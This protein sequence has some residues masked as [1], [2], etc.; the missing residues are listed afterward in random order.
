MSVGIGFLNKF[1][2][3]GLP[4][5][6]FSDKGLTVD[7]FSGDEKKVFEYIVEHFQKFERAPTKETITAETDVEFSEFPDEPIEYWLNKIESRAKSVLMSKAAQQI[8]ED[9]SEGDVGDAAQAVGLLYRE[10]EARNPTSHIL[11]LSKVAEEVVILHDKLRLSGRDVS[12]VPFGFPTL[13]RISG[14]AQP[15][16]TIAFCGRPGEAKCLPLDSLAPTED[17]TLQALANLGER[18]LASWSREDGSC[19]YEHP[20]AV[21]RVG[22]K[23]CLKLELDDGTELILSEEHRLLDGETAKE[24]EARLFKPGDWIAVPRHIPKPE[25]PKEMLQSRVIVNAMMMAEGG[26]SQSQSTWTNTDPEIIRIMKDALQADELFLKERGVKDD[27]YAIVDEKGQS[28]IEVR[29]RLR[30]LGV[31][32]GKAVS[33][34]IDDRIFRLPQDQLALWLGVF[35]SCDGSKAVQIAVTLASKTM[36]Y[37]IRHLLLRFGIYSTVSYEKMHC[38]GKSFDAWRLRVSGEYRKLF[39]EQIPIFG[40]K[41]I[42]SSKWHRGN[43]SIPAFEWLRL[44]LGEKSRQCW[45][46]EGTRKNYFRPCKLFRRGKAVGVNRH[47]LELMAKRYKFENEVAWLLSVEWTQVKKIE[48]VGEKDCVDVQMPQSPWFI[49]QQ[50]IVHNSYILLRC[51]LFAY[52]SGWRPLVVTLEM[53][54][55]QCVRRILALQAHVAT[56]DVRLGRLT[57]WGEEMFGEAVS[58]V[59]V[60]DAER[61]FYFLQ[62]TLTTTVEDLVLRIQE[63]NCNVLYVD[64]A[65]LLHTKHRQDRWERVSETAEY[66]KRI[67]SEFELP[68]ISTYQFNRQGPGNLGNIAFSDSIGQ[69]ASIVVALYTEDDVSQPIHY[70]TMK[71][72]KGREGELGSIRLKFDMERT[73][74]EE[75]EEVDFDY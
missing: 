43:S 67:A 22:K 59:T 23:S 11:T 8:L 12:G 32:R 69:L 26:V 7:S 74:I 56:S 54:V 55:I 1:L 35:Y 36:V 19:L 42:R 61:P 14:G 31:E 49:C 70:R 51:A 50:T 5:S 44:L 15:G 37:Q 28:G 66:L 46:I 20:V 30:R 64:G 3:D 62:G 58:D 71:L 13:D 25:T 45:H 2:D 48:S 4:A 47:Q 16:D 18:K 39:V 33:K 27:G 38:E 9:L 63:L 53:P 72:L 57:H 52:L 24:K 68:I 17:G 65:Y 21:E 29:L 6:F 60:L 75:E 41:N 10:L 40:L 34:K 73:S